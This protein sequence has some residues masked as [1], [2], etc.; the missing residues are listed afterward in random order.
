MLE[1]MVR[2]GAPVDTYIAA[3]LAKMP[4]YKLYIVLNALYLTPEQRKVIRQRICGNNHTVLWVYGPGFVTD[5][6]L[7]VESTSELVVGMRLRMVPD[8]VRPRLALTNMDHDITR[9]LPPGLSFGTHDPIGPIFFCDDT[10]AAILGQLTGMRG[11]RPTHNEIDGGP[12]LAVKDMGTWR[13][14][15]CGV[16][17]LPAPLLRGIARWAGVHIYSDQDDVVYATHSLLAIHARHSGQRS[18]LLPKALD[19]VDAFTEQPVAKGVREFQVNLAPN[20]T[21]LWLI[22]AP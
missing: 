13:S 19:V 18:V 12:G 17:N 3:D 6:G 4:D 11:Q 2:I 14:V 10:E 15:W 16:P 7:S 9:G 21:G 5:E 22:S 20:Q 8:W 1:Q